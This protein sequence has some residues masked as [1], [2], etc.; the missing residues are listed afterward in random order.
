[1][2][3]IK[4]LTKCFSGEKI[5]NCSYRIDLDGYRAFRQIVTNDAV[6]KYVDNQLLNTAR[7]DDC[8]SYVIHM[9]ADGDNITLHYSQK[10]INTIRE[11]GAENIKGTIVDDEYQFF[12]LD[13]SIYSELMKE[14]ECE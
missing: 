3:N 11:I 13:E 9:D 2:N 7:L 12:L 14:F 8:E 5:Y 6:V 10:L 1:M 4:I